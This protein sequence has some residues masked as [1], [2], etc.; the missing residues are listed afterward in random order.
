MTNIERVPIRE[1]KRFKKYGDVFTQIGYN[2][3]TNL[4][5][6]KR[7]G[8]GV[9]G[10]PQ[11]QFDIISYE[12]VKGREFADQN[13]NVV[14]V[15]PCSSDF[16][17]YALYFQSEELATWCCEIGFD[18]YKEWKQRTRAEKRK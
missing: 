4:Y 8:K 5:L 6:Y 7:V 3:N 9:K 18:A 14:K 11:K 15:Y 16:G 10:H 13:G 2:P 17:V 1:L 12:V